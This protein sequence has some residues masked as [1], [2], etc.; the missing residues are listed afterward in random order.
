MANTMTVKEASLLWNI[1]ECRIS[2]LCKQERIVGT[3]K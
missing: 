3:K 1:S 2:Y